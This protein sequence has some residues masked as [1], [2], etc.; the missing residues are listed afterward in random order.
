[1]PKHLTVRPLAGYA[2]WEVSLANYG[3]WD[4]FSV[5]SGVKVQKL[6][7][8][9]TASAKIYDETSRTARIYDH[10]ERD[11]ILLAMSTEA[12][13][14][15]QW[16][17]GGIY[18]TDSETGIETTIGINGKMAIKAV[19]FPSF[20]ETGRYTVKA[21][22][23]KQSILHILEKVAQTE[24][25]KFAA[26]KSYTALQGVNVDF[27]ELEDDLKYYLQK[28]LDA[29]AFGMDVEMVIVSEIFFNDEFLQKRREWLRS[30]QEAEKNKDKNIYITE[31]AKR[32]SADADQTTQKPSH[33]AEL[34]RVLNP[35]TGASS[36]A[37]DPYIPNNSYA[38]GVGKTAYC[39]RCGTANDSTDL[40]CKNCGKQLKK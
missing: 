20:A 36:V 4:T 14:Q 6:V 38:G 16:G 22:E 1:M 18:F 35:F 27:R 17:T 7:N 11:V 26:G 25:R 39:S 12:V 3:G 8:G 9:R 40:Y 15:I 33:S 34:E 30:Q 32:Y 13:Q 24:L 2:V 23:M 29:E 31:L 21:E 37:C 19:Q 5:G 10:G 28:S